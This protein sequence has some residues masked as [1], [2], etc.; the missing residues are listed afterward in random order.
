VSGIYLFALTLPSNWW[1]FLVPPL[2]SGYLAAKL[3]ELFRSRSEKR[4]QQTTLRSLEEF[5]REAGADLRLIP[6]LKLKSEYMQRELEAVKILPKLEANIEHLVSDVG[7]VQL[8]LTPLKAIPKL[9]VGFEN[10]ARVLAQLE[11]DLP[12]VKAIPKLQNEIANVVAA[13]L[14]MPV[15]FDQLIATHLATCPYGPG[16]AP[17]PTDTTPSGNTPAKTDRLPAEEAQSETDRHTGQK[18]LRE[19][20]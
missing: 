4:E 14:N 5:R 6:E 1:W 3:N 17:L 11:T 13:T 20:A 2:L 8:Q 19:A 10:T 9:E 7:R 15:K 18:A 12:F 16:S